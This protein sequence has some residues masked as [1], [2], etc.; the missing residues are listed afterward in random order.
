MKRETQIKCCRACGN[1]KLKE[2]I[3]LGDQHVTNFVADK[4]QQK[5]KHPLDLV[6]CDP[7]NGGCGLLQL[8]HN[9]PPELM[10]DEQYWY[11]SAISSTIKNDLKDIVNHAKDL[12]ELNKGDIVIDIGSNDGTLLENYSKDITVVGFEPSKNVWKEADEKGILTINNFFNAQNFKDAFTDKRAKIIT[13]ISMFYDLEDPNAFLKDITDVLDK[14]GLFIIQQNYLISMLSKNAFDNICHEHREY[15]SLYSLKKLLD[16]H[17]LEIFDVSQN[18]ING[19]SIRTYIKFKDNK[20]LGSEE[21]YKRVK[22]VEDMELELGIDNLF[23]YEEFVTRIEKIKK[24]LLDFLNKEKEAGK[25]IYIYGASTRGNVILQYF[26]LSPELITAAV[27]KNPDKH[28]KKTVGT[29]I[30]IISPEKFREKNP[31]YL[32]VM[33]WHFYEEIKEQEKEWFNK[34]GCFIVPLPELKREV[35]VAI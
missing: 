13:A 12:V 11:K 24:D 1:E 31:D 28:G 22:I 2:I 7:T 19:G 21:S 26:D 17:G 9:T 15:Y 16:K 27:D 5:D 33:T 32:L 25:E 14:D 23:I 34:G 3:S 4:S 30:P 8:N 6:L 29:L 18:D 20:N 35:H 10:W